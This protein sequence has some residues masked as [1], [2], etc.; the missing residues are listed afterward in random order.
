MAHG[1]ARC[2]AALE[3]HRS[4]TPALQQLRPQRHCCRQR[5]PPTLSSAS[6]LYCPHEWLAMDSQV[7]ATPVA[8]PQSQQNA[9]RHSR[10]ACMKPGHACCRPVQH[11][12]DAQVTSRRYKTSQAA[13]NQT[14]QSCFAGVFLHPDA[15]HRRSSSRL[16]A[17]PSSHGCRVPGLRVSHSRLSG[18]R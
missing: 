18:K 9:C 2:V 1:P 13:L 11:L 14:V 15:A 5:L 3:Q 7:W 17:C 6:S 16:A 10:H 8:P 4:L 12:P